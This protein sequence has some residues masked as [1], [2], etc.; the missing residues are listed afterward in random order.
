MKISN[1]ATKRSYDRSYR[2]GNSTHFDQDEDEDSVGHN[3][4]VSRASSLA[5]AVSESKQYEPVMI[6]QG[7]C[8]ALGTNA[9][10]P[11]R[12]T[13]C[14]G[15]PDC[16]RKGHPE[17]RSGG[18][19]GKAGWMKPVA[20]RGG[21]VIGGIADT[22]M[23]E[24][25]AGALNEENR[26]KNREAA[27]KAKTPVV[28]ITSVELGK[29]RGKDESPESWQ[30]T[31]ED[32]EDA[33]ELEQEPKGVARGATTSDEG[34]GGTM[35]HPNKVE[36][37][38]RI[39][40]AGLR[41]LTE[42]TKNVATKQQA[43]VRGGPKPPLFDVLDTKDD[44]SLWA[45]P[46]AKFNQGDPVWYH[47]TTG[48]EHRGTVV[49]V[50]QDDNY[51]VYYTVD[52]GGR[53]EVNTLEENLSS[54]AEYKSVR[55]TSPPRS[56]KHGIDADAIAKLLS[57]QDL[58]MQERLRERDLRHKE[59]NDQMQE[60]MS[61]MFTD[62]FKTHLKKEEEVTAP[63]PRGRGT[64][65]EG[66][67]RYYGVA[68]P[69]ENRGVYATHEEAEALTAVP[70]GRMK[71]FRTY[72]EAVEYIEEYKALH[73]DGGPGRAKTWYAV[74]KGAHGIQGVF[75][76]WA[77]AQPLLEGG[78]DLCH[79]SC[80]TKEEA[81]EFVDQYNRTQER[82]KEA[83]ERSDFRASAPGDEPAGTSNPARAGV[84]SQGDLEQMGGRCVGPDESAGKKGTLF[85][86]DAKNREDLL[87]GLMP[88]DDLPAAVQEHL[89]EQIRDTV[90]H[91]SK[92]AIDS[93]ELSSHN[94]M[95]VRALNSF[96]GKQ[97]EQVYG[98]SATDSQW[99]DTKRVSLDKKKVSSLAIL[100]ERAKN[101]Y[102]ETKS[103]EETTLANLV[104][105]L[106][107]IGYSPT[108]S[109]L[110]GQTSIIYFLSVQTH[111]YWR[112]LHAH[113]QRVGSR[114]WAECELEIGFHSDN[115]KEIRNAYTTRL[116]VM[117]MTYIYLREGS[118][119]SWRSMKLQEKQQQL[120]RGQITDLN[121]L[122]LQLQTETEGLKK[123]I[124]QQ[125]FDKMLCY[126]CLTA[127]VHQ[128]GSGQCPMKDK[129]KEEAV[130]WG[131]EQMAKKGK[132]KGKS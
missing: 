94:T 123:S 57:K 4:T 68:G 126:H 115:L 14:S 49:G 88:E 17:A 51:P 79:T 55:S 86:F 16:K 35:C 69:P 117:A 103:F 71:S 45:A 50:H 39:D 100:D 24:K 125:K 90:K 15:K 105:V 44:P 53:R 36:Q 91:P 75:D 124:K 129:P 25:E 109:R 132:G 67:R 72:D 19:V 85:G 63:P 37:A 33:L 96:Q 66:T 64:G 121:T 84:E 31:C 106:L 41:A 107:R 97:S 22:L 58:L 102:D 3:S 32:L 1:K 73:G 127:D 116:Q 98:G 114:N 38:E 104:S 131:Q 82:I 112:E 11:G 56:T 62:M 118:A 5:T 9:K 77:C 28:G 30:L 128:G 46:G 110:W 93:S 119:N 54:R 26:R 130:K 113:L 7:R 101:L 61:K 59:Q 42:V 80:K 70:G 43:M 29:S 10:Y 87:A 108:I 76:S 99:D 23:D 20:T 6:A 47:G 78:T 60:A 74:A 83:R 95:L 92:A 34:T 120:F 2:Q 89:T 12:L 65:E 21:T 13:V 8:R 111:T 122:L 27:I 81:E 18:R 40:D 52:L 48:T